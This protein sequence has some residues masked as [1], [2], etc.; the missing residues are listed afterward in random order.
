[1]SLPLHEGRD[2]LPIGVQC[3]GRFGDESGLFRLAGQLESSLP[4][5]DRTP[6]LHVTREV[7][8]G[9]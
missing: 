4:W 1:M 2:N 6:Q 8:E 7:G 5:K 9:R 3:V